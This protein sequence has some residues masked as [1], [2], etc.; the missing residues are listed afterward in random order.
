LLSINA[1]IE[2]ARAGV[3]GKGF[4][5]VAREVS[6]LAE[7]TSVNVKDSTLLIK[8]FRKTIK[9]GSIRIT[10]VIDFF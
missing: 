10:E 7:E 9:E 4:A 3:H 8:T 1:S 5:I 6:N 2:S